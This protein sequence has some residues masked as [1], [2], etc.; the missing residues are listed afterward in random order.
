MARTTRDEIWDRTLD[1][2]VRG[3]ETVTPEDVAEEIEASERTVRECLL[4]MYEAGYLI[5]RTSPSG[6]VRY[7]ASDTFN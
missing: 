5:R 6:T 2:T 4:A 3:D 7:V 1:R